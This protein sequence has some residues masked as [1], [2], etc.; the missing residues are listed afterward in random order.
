MALGVAF[1]SGIQ[2]SS[3]DMKI[4]EDSYFDDSN[5]MDIRVIST[6]GLTED[7]LEA[8]RKVEDVSYVE[9][10]WQEDV[11]CGEE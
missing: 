2:S 3:P 10:S 5:L 11:Q 6:M 9:G 8:I 7:D 1:Y 4:T